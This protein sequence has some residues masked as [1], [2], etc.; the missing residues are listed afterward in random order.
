MLIYEIIVPGGWL[1][2]EDDSWVRN[3]SNQL[4]SL[5]SSFY[6][7]NVALNLF[8][9]AQGEF[10][11]K[12]NDRSLRERERTRRTELQMEAQFSSTPNT[13]GP[14]GEI[15]QLETRLKR[16]QWSMGIPPRQFWNKPMFLYAKMFLF[17]VDDFERKL[18]VLSDE[19]EVPAILADLH[20][21]IMSLFPDLRGVR[22]TAHHMEDRQRGLDRNKAFTPQPTTTAGIHSLSGLIFNNLEGTKFG[23]TM[24]TGYFGQIDVSDDSMSGLKDILQAVYNSFNWDGHMELLP[25]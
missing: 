11:A 23:S 18:K 17:S 25:A 12:M 7:A 14:F 5:Q 10:I 22:N 21:Q 6:D 1:N 9:E 2:Y 16:E 13:L 4:S 24:G 20:K 15:L 8:I 19:P 3:I